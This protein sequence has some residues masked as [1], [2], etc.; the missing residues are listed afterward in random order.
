MKRNKEEKQKKFRITN[1]KSF[2]DFLDNNKEIASVFSDEPEILSEIFSSLLT[3]M[4]VNINKG[5]KEK[6]TKDEFTIK[7]DN[8]NINPVNYAVF[9]LKYEDS[10]AKFLYYYGKD[11]DL[12]KFLADKNLQPFGSLEFNKNKYEGTAGTIY[13]KFEECNDLEGVLLKEIPSD[14]ESKNTNIDKEFSKINKKNTYHGLFLPLRNGKKQLFGVLMLINNTNLTQIDNLL[15]NGNTVIK[16]EKAKRLS[17]K[18]KKITKKDKHFKLTKTVKEEKKAVQNVV[19]ILLDKIKIIA[20]KERQYFYYPLIDNFFRYESDS[21]EKEISEEM[22]IFRGQ[23]RKIASLEMDTIDGI[24]GLYCGIKEKDNTGKN[25]VKY[26]FPKYASERVYES[27][28]LLNQFE[29]RREGNIDEVREHLIHML[30]VYIIGVLLLVKP[31]KKHK[32]SSKKRSNYLKLWK[33]IALFHDF[34][35]PIERFEDWYKTYVKKIATDKS[36]TEIKAYRLL[37]NT[38]ISGLVNKSI[39]LLIDFCNIKDNRVALKSSLEKLILE[40]LFDNRDH[41][42]ISGILWY[43]LIGS[44]GNLTGDL[45][46][47]DVNKIFSAIIFHNLH[48]WIWNEFKAEKNGKIG[49]SDCNFRN[50]TIPNTENSLLLRTLLLADNIQ[51]FGRMESKIGEDSCKSFN[52]YENVELG[53]GKDVSKIKIEFDNKG[54]YTKINEKEIINMLEGKQEK[55]EVF[56]K[57]LKIWLLWEVCSIA[58]YSDFIE[59]TVLIP[60]FK[61]ENDKF[62]LIKLENFFREIRDTENG[63]G[64]KIVPRKIVKVFSEPI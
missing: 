63:E 59:T 57:Y 36:I 4:K 26:F 41:A 27:F 35:Y 39:D 31:F 29:M 7:Q 50:F 16:V 30:K 25:K 55:N 34:G 61:N 45:V 28:K 49:I 3:N 21:Y 19:S 53:D 64:E 12:K 9:F 1:W 43:N 24:R 60:N 5:C 52:V 51:D 54:D 14:E 23:L 8:K 33:H 42:I 2:R 22:E 38:N 6:G 58:D 13:E 11:T 15:E 44:A 48:K 32:M 47:D 40:N 20:K 37:Q 10:E 18:I 46:D 56:Y 17:Q 62:T